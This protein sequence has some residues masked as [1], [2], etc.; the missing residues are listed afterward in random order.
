MLTIY[1]LDAE[2]KRDRTVPSVID[3]T[4][5]DANAVFELLRYHLRRLGEHQ[6][7]ELTLIGDRAKWIWTRAEG[8]RDDLGLAPERSRSRSATRDNPA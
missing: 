7:E 6:A 5:G 2:G 1:V 8:L 4:L 3:G